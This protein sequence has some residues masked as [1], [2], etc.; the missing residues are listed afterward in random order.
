M[1]STGGDQHPC[2]QTVAP[3][4]E[5]IWRHLSTTVGVESGSHGPHFALGNRDL[6]LRHPCRKVANVGPR[7]HNRTLVGR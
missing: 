3:G 2:L 1:A 5:F 7:L 4:N 6:I